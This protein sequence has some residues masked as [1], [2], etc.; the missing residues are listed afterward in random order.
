MKKQHASLIH[1]VQRHNRLICSVPPLLAELFDGPVSAL[2]QKC[3]RGLHEIHWASAQ[4]DEYIQ[5]MF[6]T[7][8]EFERLLITC[9]ST[10]SESVHKALRYLQSTPFFPQPPPHPVKLQELMKRFHDH[11]VQLRLQLSHKSSEIFFALQRLVQTVQSSPLNHGRSLDADLLSTEPVYQIRETYEELLLSSYL[12]GTIRSILLVRE[13]FG[14]NTKGRDTFFLA[15]P[16]PT[17]PEDRPIVEVSVKLVPSMVGSSLVLSPSIE[18]ITEAMAQIL[19]SVVNAGLD[20]VTWRGTSLCLYANYCQQTMSDREVLRCS[21]FYYAAIHTMKRR[22]EG[23]C[24]KFRVYEPLWSGPE[25]Q[26]FEKILGTARS[27]VDF[28]GSLQRLHALR[29]QVDETSDTV[30]VQFLWVNMTELK[31]GLRREVNKW[32]QLY[33]AEA[34]SLVNHDADQLTALFNKIG[35]ELARQVGDL[36]DVRLIMKALDEERALELDMSLRI[37]SVE[38]A[39]A[40]LQAYGVNIAKDDTESVFGLSSHWATIMSAARGAYDF[41]VANQRRYRSTLLKDVLRFKRDIAEFK[42]LFD[43]EGPHVAGV[44]PRQAVERIKLFERGCEERLQRASNFEM[45]E[46]L[47]ALPCTEYPEIVWVKKQLSLLSKLYGLHTVVVESLAEYESVLWI[48]LDFQAPPSQTEA[49]Q[50]THHAH[51]VQ[52]HR[53]WCVVDVS[54][55]MFASLICSGCKSR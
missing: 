35:R 25:Q 46:Q 5:S 54:Q 41:L 30:S 51:Y 55:S 26:A 21:V 44:T 49:Q 32:I 11:H 50:Q 45:N 12:H 28:K 17:L 53:Y 22:W 39:L 19:L 13:L 33:G 3:V 42:N 18:Q 23:F 27:A 9:T 15:H 40:M 8:D 38:E 24:K 36:D 14:S 6:D 47:F 52:T 1:I 37:A 16:P 29:A 20:M 34:L 31:A 4:L 43:D 2:E 7:L 48:E 10:L